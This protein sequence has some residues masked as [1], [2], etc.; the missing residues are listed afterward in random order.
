VKSN[1]AKT[2]SVLACAISGVA[3]LS[4]CGSGDQVV[5]TS[6]AADK[7]SVAESTPSAQTTLTIP[8][9]SGDGPTSKADALASARPPTPEEA[10]PYIVTLHCP[11]GLDP[12]ALKSAQAAAARGWTAFMRLQ[13]FPDESG[14]PQRA[15]A[16]TSPAAVSHRKSVLEATW[17]PAAAAERA[18]VLDR[19]LPR[20]ADDPNQVLWTSW[21]ATFEPVDMGTADELNACVRL[22]YHETIGVTGAH[23]Q[24]F[25]PRP[26]MG[27]GTY[28]SAQLKR[29][30]PSDPWLLVATRTSDNNLDP[31]A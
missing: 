14:G 10:A 8:D 21:S 2:A 15:A 1:T 9:P 17:V 16:V 29:A 3:L 30:S 11:T 27:P 4:G 6:I 31:L 25:G 22:T 7:P 23:G 5:H 20:A 18:Q 24:R 12:A 13:V 19:V 26:G 28:L